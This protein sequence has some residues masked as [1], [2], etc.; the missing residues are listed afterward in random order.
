MI[1]FYKGHGVAFTMMDSDGV[2]D[3]LVPMW[4]DSGFDIV[5]P[6]EVGT[7]GESPV[8]MREKFGSRLKMIGGIDKHVIAKGEEAIRKHLLELVPVVRQGGYLPI[9]DHRI[10]PEVSYQD[11]L[12]YIRVFNEVFNG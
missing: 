10:P 5:F 7:W 6:I 3:K 12:T 8:R 11:M 4:L 1:E 2:V 9:P